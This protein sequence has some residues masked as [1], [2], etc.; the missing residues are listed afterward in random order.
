MCL[1]PFWCLNSASGHAEHKNCGETMFLAS[2]LNSNRIH[3]MCKSPSLSAKGPDLI[4]VFKAQPSNWASQKCNCLKRKLWH[5]PLVLSK[6][7]PQV[8]GFSKS[9]VNPGPKLLSGWEE[10]NFPLLW[11]RQDYSLFKDMNMSL[12]KKRQRLGHSS[13]QEAIWL[14]QF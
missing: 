8:R 9:M 2:C 3:K 6:S 13:G 7:L 11:G 14:H 4:G 1:L 12:A 5:L 10:T